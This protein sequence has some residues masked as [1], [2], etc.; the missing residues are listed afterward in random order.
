MAGDELGNC[1]REL[2]SRQQWTQQDLA[3]K[4]DVTRQTI[5]AIEKGQY[6]PS[7]V[8]ALKIAVAFQRPLEEVFWLNN[9]GNC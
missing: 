1:L 3:A 7:V 2:R 8:L 5:I 9:A 4:V 6:N